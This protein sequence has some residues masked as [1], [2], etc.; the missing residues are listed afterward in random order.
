[1]RASQLNARNESR[2]RKAQSAL[3]GGRASLFRGNDARRKRRERVRAAR[4]EAIMSPGWFDGRSGAR[5]WTSWAR[6]RAERGS[7]I[8][9]ERVGAG[10]AAVSGR[11]RRTEARA[12]PR[13]SSLFRVK[14]AFLAR[15]IAR[16]RSEGV[17]ECVR[18]PE[19]TRCFPRG[20]SSADPD[21][22]TRLPFA[23]DS[24]HAR[25]MRTSCA[26]RDSDPAR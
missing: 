26:S 12:G 16:A 20:R 8:T 21:R 25:T 13:V 24:G 3:R 2:G 11:T 15:K 17:L 7:T 5:R 1:M 6:E 22:A 9:D 10:V 23:F 4:D 18:E 14:I 19:L